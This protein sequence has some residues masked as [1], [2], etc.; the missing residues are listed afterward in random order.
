MREH[1]TQ[2]GVKIGAW[3]SSSRGYERYGRNPDHRDYCLI[4]APAE[5]VR[6]ISGC[7]LCGS[8]IHDPI[9]WVK[10]NLPVRYLCCGACIPAA[11]EKYKAEV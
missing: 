10:S 4:H 9:P 11:N 5:R 2:C 3:V 7:T 6:V 1:C 8:A